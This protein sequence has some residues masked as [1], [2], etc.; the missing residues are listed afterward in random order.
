MLSFR[1][2]LIAIFFITSLTSAKEITPPF[3][4]IKT[5]NG[6]P[7][8]FFKSPNVPLFQIEFAFEGGADLDPP[9]K[10]GLGS[11]MAS[12]IKRG[13]STLNEDQISQR[14][15]DLASSIE[16]QASDLHIY[17][18]AY[19]LSARSQETLTL[20]QE[21]LHKPQ[22]VESVF[23]R[24]KQNKI[25]YIHS[26]SDYPGLLAKHI[27]DFLVF[28]KTHR[29]RPI[30]GLGKELKKLELSDIRQWYFT[31]IRSDRLKVLVTG[32]VQDEL[33]K[34]VV[35]L[36][37]TLPCHTCGNPKPSVQSWS[38]KN[39]EVSEKTILLIPRPGLSQAHIRMG[40][41]GVRRNVPEYYDLHVAETVLSGFF[42]SRM[43]QVIREKLNLT[44]SIDA[45]FSFGIET[46]MF[47][48]STST[49][50]K[51]VGALVKKILEL[52]T[53]FVQ[54]GITQE[55]IIAAQNY[56]IGSFPIALQDVFTISSG[57][58]TGMLKG[59]DKGFLEE[60]EGRVSLVTPQGVKAALQKYLPLN[61]LKTVIVGNAPEISKKLKQAKLKYVLRDAKEFL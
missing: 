11:L 1:Y 19:G 61:Q 41:V 37:E 43:N 38:H 31:L 6:V 45:S 12:M 54:N 26:I 4:V 58:F 32:G 42:A 33:L 27:L 47:T 56:L 15:D 60:Y 44:Y 17:L 20:L 50:N 23:N 21:I 16:I 59:L 30:G 18:S 36:I 22:F 3:Q 14:L 51:N 34:Q 25:E 8:Y 13:S 29:A 52:L 49:E 57:F 46:G 24:I 5:K 40:L 7:I 39:W 35:Q 48:V 10:S 53:D 9:G 2:L 55:E 28:N